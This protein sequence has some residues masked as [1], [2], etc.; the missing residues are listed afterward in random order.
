MNIDLICTT[1]SYSLSGK[2]VTLNIQFQLVDL[3]QLD[4][5]GLPKVLDKKVITVRQN[6]MDTDALSNL[7][8]KILREVERYLVQARDNVSVLNAMFG[9]LDPEEIIGIL[10]SNLETDVKALVADVFGG[11]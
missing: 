10:K 3:D 2:T 7:K 5:D 1:L 9:T 11:V 8:A 6:I 4:S